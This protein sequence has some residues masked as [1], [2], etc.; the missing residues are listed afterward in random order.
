DE[1]C[2]GDAD[3]RRELDAMLG[4]HETGSRLLLEQ[5][6]E[7]ADAAGFSELPPGARV[8]PWE[9]AELVGQGGMGEVYRA[10]R[11]DGEYRQTVA[12]KVLRPGYHTA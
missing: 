9:I 11:G 12:V 2:G 3:L 8:G 5:R 1:A 4:A 10:E 7:Q 6:F